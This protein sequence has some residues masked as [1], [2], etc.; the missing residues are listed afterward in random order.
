[1]RLNDFI[2]LLQNYKRLG[3]GEYN[4]RCPGHDDKKNSLTI[5]EA[6]DERILIHC[7]AGCRSADII[8]ALGLNMSDLYP[9]DK[10]ET[11]KR[12]IAEY[13]Y[14]D[15]NGNVVH[16]TIRYEPKGFAQARP[17]GSGGWIY[18]LKGIK[19]VIYNLPAVQEAIKRGD[20]I[21]I[22]EGEKD[23]ENLKKLNKVATTSPMG[24]GKWRPEYSQYLL[25]AS[26][27]IIPDND[28]P[29][30]Q[31]AESIAASLVGMAKS[32]KVVDLKNELHELPP[33][34]DIT[35]FFNIIGKKADALNRL[36]KLI[37]ATPKWHSKNNNAPESKVPKLEL[38]NAR[39]LQNME[40]PPIKYIVDNLI[41]AGLTLL[42]G[43]PKIGKSWLMIWLCI[44]VSN[45]ALVWGNRTLKGR[46]L[47]LALE[48]N[49]NRLKDR[50]NKVLN[51]A[52]AP[53]GFHYAI[54]AH[55]VDDG[56]VEQ[57]E[58]HMKEYPDTV[59]IVIDTF[60]KVRGNGRKDNMYASDYADA[61]ILKALA[62]KFNI[63][64]LLIHHLRKMKDDDIFNTISGSTGL[65]GAVDT[66][67]AI[68]KDKR[69]DTQAILHATG[70]DI[71]P[72]EAVL[73]F[74]KGKYIWELISVDAE[75]F[76][77][78]QAFNYDAVVV[79]LKEFMGD[80]NPL[81]EG[82]PSELFEEF[83]K[84]GIDDSYYNYPTT[85]A[86]LGRQLN[87]L[88]SR[89]D[90]INIKLRSKRTSKTRVISLQYMVGDTGE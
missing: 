88:S 65:T 52:E 35:G 67:L 21:F 58:D 83:M 30:K 9:D 10:K 73:T 16:K 48:D 18:N 72:M 41:S 14:H 85:P 77:E 43:A 79:F 49:M 28:E 74:N 55:T 78:E 47:Y 37:M 84:S 27:I 26:V 12:I 57:I 46:T 76:R 87:A 51:G 3:N 4:A 8:K 69:N 66:M 5:R 45:G 56:L 64:I 23:V 40:L 90:K 42:A 7:H 63:S 36:D 75:K 59:L 1:M 61:G 24:A 13:L 17:D 86:I 39:E 15:L 29:G 2:P 33:K 31:H 80:Q 34:G 70:R 50:M 44:Q 11:K 32:I 19:P 38:I 89:L 25:N 20:P 81:W 53:D 82:N 62:D 22:V 60:Q 54:K 6:D 68:T 71:E